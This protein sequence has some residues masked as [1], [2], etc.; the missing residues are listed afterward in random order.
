MTSKRIIVSILLGSIAAAAFAAPAQAAGIT[1]LKAGCII[2]G[3]ATADVD[4]RP[5]TGTYN[6]GPK[7]L[8]IDCNYSVTRTQTKTETQ[9]LSTGTAEITASSAGNF[10]NIEGCGALGTAADA[11][12]TVTSVTTSPDDPLAEQMLLNGDF[13]YNI[14]FK[15]FENGT[16]EWDHDAD[17]AG[18]G[19]PFTFGNLPEPS[20]PV[21]TG[22][23]S[24]VPWHDD[25]EPG[26]FLYNDP[27]GIY[28]NIQGVMLGVGCSNGFTVEG[29][30]DGVMV[31]T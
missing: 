6:F 10:D 1:K 21:G 22:D 2:E 28:P 7:G 12:P 24:L 23:I 9:I 11:D 25:Q 8:G 15:T 17:E 20:R 5:N 3:S 16:L 27:D 19:N 13:G 26:E 30:A 18:G 4:W 14:V 31:T 29:V